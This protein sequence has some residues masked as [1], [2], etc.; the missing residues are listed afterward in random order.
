MERA[1]FDFPHDVRE[2]RMLAENG[3][4]RG[5]PGIMRKVFVPFGTFRRAQSPTSKPASMRNS[6]TSTASTVRA[7]KKSGAQLSEARVSCLSPAGGIQDNTVNR[8]LLMSNSE[9]HL[10]S[11]PMALLLR[12]IGT[13]IYRHRQLDCPP[14]HLPLRPFLPSGGWLLSVSKQTFELLP[15]PTRHGHLLPRPINPTASLILHDGLLPHLSAARTSRQSVRQ[16]PRE[17]DAQGCD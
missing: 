13:V 5:Y 6:S 4:F 10:A 9:H 2:I 16:S 8:L 12:A 1:E 7:A 17:A 3:V 15:L 14:D 11:A